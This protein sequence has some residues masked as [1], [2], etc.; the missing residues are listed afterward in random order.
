MN[1]ELA[2]CFHIN[3]CGATATRPCVARNFAE[4]VKARRREA[5]RRAAK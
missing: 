1:E 5:A 3:H 2:I 4:A